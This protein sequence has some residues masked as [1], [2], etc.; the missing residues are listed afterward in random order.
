MYKEGGINQQRE[1]SMTAPKSLVEFKEPSSVS[2]SNL[3]T[4]P[5]IS[6]KKPRHQVEASVV[7]AQ[8]PHCFVKRFRVN[9]AKIFHLLIVVT[10]DP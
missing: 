7:E 1:V 5:P 8:P 10:A 4:V 9:F 2:G 6:K 3:I